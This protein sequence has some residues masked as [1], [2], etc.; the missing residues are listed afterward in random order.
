MGRSL[1]QPISRDFRKSTCLLSSVIP[2]WSQRWQEMCSGTCMGVPLQCSL[3]SQ[4]TSVQKIKYCLWICSYSIIL[5]EIATRSDPIPVSCPNGAHD[6]T[7]TT[8]LLCLVSDGFLWKAMCFRLRSQMWRA[9]GVLLCLS[10]SPPR[11][12]APV[13]VQLTT[14]RYVHLTSPA[15]FKLFALL[16]CFAVPHC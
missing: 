7:N 11:L 3:A 12:T 14:W 8:C 2:T 6:T 1:C 4:K 5:L 16:R 15:C 9:H 10:S 13:P